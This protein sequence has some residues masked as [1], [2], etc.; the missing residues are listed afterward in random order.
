[1]T[2]IKRNLNFQECL[3][4]QKKKIKKLNDNFISEKSQISP[5]F[6]ITFSFF[7]LLHTIS[8]LK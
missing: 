5:L 7:C 6:L 8:G 2:F 1:M 3:L 4:Y